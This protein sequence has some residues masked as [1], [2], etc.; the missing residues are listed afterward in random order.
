MKKPLI[1]LMTT[2]VSLFCSCTHKELDFNGTTDLTVEFD[3]RNVPTADPPSMMLVAFSD[4]TQPIQKPFDNR[5]GGTITL[6][7]GSYQLVAFND[8]SEFVSSRGNTWLDYEVYSHQTELATFSRMFVGTRNI[9]RG[10]GTEGQTIIA[11]PDEVWTSAADEVIVTGSIGR[12]VTMPMEP[13][14]FVV[15]FAI[16][17]VDNIEFVDEVLATISG[18]SGSWWPAR[19]VASYTECIIPF[20]LSRTGQSYSGSVRTFGYRPTN[21]DGEEV[22]HLFVI[23]AEMTDG[24]K[25]YYTFDVTDQMNNIAPGDGGSVTT[26]VTIELDEL[27]LPKPL[28]DGTGLAPDVADWEEVSIPI[29]M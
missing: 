7:I 26:E 19:H 29:D 6:P 11:E 21:A 20:N 10:S 2:A 27:P 9:P 15:H 18:M 28:N 1:L 4:L 22:K 25:K 13:A 24:S 14:T 5:N 8:H 12:R 3:W 23:Y 17:N 16:K